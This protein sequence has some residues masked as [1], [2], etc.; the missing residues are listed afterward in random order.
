M[1]TVAILQA[2]TG[3]SRLPGKVLADLGGKPVLVHCV[4]RAKMIDGVDAVCLATTTATADD[5][6]ATLVDT[7]SGVTLFRGSENDVLNRYLGAARETE[8]QIVL[9]LTCDCPLIDPSVCAAVIALR[10]ETDAPYA[11]NVMRREWPHGLDCE[12]FLMTGLESAATHATE[13]YDREHVTPYIRR[14]AGDRAVD[15]AGPGGRAARQRWTLDYQE[16]LDFLRALFPHLP[17]GRMTGWQEVMN[18]IE[19]NP[20]LA[21]INADRSIQADGKVAP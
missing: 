13:P 11:A 15:L 7:I 20:E 21:A 17:L 16:D 1:R 5:A 14:H 9:R 12:A 8:A 3:S 19:K 6:V 18:V 10:A 2:R 4:E